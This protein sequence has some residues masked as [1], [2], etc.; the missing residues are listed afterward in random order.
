M[1]PASEETLALAEEMGKKYGVSVVPVNCLELD[2]TEIKRIMASVLFEF[3]V[4]E[5]KVEMP[6]WIS[7]LEKDHWLRAAVYG[8][9]QRAASKVT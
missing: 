2:E 3:P 6:R 7:T 9:I 5:V 8:S 4:K 1:Y